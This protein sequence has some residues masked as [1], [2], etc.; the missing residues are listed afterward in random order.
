MLGDGVSQKGSLVDETKARFDFSHD[1]AMSAGECERVEALVRTMVR[2]PL[3]VHIQT[4]P[5]DKALEINNLRAVFGERYPDP[6]R[7]VSIGPTVPELLQEPASERWADFSIELCGGTHVPATEALAEFALVEESAVAKGVRR[8]V[9]VTGGL[10]AQAIATGAELQ[11]RLGEVTSLDAAKAGAEE[12]AAARK[13]LTAIKLETD[14][15]TCPIH[16]KAELRATI[17]A[18]D[19]AMAKRAKQLAAGDADRAAAAAV[20]S[21]VAAAEAG[22]KY[23]VLSLGDG[24]SGKGMQPLVQKVVKQSGVAV[25]A[26]SVADGKLACMA[27]APADAAAELPANKWLQDVLA[28][29]NGRGGGSPAQAQGSSTEVDGVERAIEAATSLAKEALGA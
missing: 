17:S 27:A 20:A 13:G 1:K 5:L 18:A 29:V 6:V 10:A 22:Q 12:V 4:V 28:T 21:A 24:V 3:P 26:L 9:G 14:G 16:V 2:E 15:A 25:F 7:V 23:V 8:V 19:K 11:A